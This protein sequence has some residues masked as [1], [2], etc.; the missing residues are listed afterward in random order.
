MCD[1]PLA[2]KWIRTYCTM[3]NKTW[4]EQLN[5]WLERSYGYVALGMF[6][7]IAVVMTNWFIWP[8]YQRM[9][10]AGILQYRDMTV[11]LDQRRAYIQDLAVMQ[12]EY[13]Q[14]DQRIVRAIDL[15]LPEEYADGPVYAEVEQLL[16]GT[17]YSIQS[18]NIAVSGETETAD[19]IYEVV[20]LSL[21]ISAV[22]GTASY[23]DFKTLLARLE[24]YPHLLNL[25]SLT[26][27]PG[28]SA[29]TF[30]LKTYQRRTTL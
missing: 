25:E 11:V 24:Q 20:T 15:A 6:G 5:S 18:V 29:Y 3:D 1:L 10:S 17:P 12:Q 7:V 27:S 16:Q 23:D 8:Q 2:C 28:T 14:L 13:E 30:V 26:Y 4:L 19:P 21:N 22:N 9:Q